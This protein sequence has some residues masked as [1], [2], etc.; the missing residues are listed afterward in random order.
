MICYNLF[1]DCY[2]QNINIFYYKD[3][4]K[5]KVNGNEVYRRLLQGYFDERSEEEVEGEIQLLNHL[6]INKLSLTL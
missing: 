2:S 3:D 6:S 5:L 1:T 4:R